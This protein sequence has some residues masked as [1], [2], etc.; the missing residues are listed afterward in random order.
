VYIQK[1]LAIKAIIVAK[2]TPPPAYATAT[3]VVETT[4]PRGAVTAIA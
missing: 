3:V 1:A 2:T 4:L